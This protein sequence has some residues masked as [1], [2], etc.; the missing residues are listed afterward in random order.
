MEGTRQRRKRVLLVRR[1]YENS[2]LELAQ[3]AAAYERVLPE[4]GVVLA[5]SRPRAK[6]LAVPPLVLA[7]GPLWMEPSLSGTGGRFS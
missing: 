1:D 3:L 6:L 5:E 2:R 4:A 7:S